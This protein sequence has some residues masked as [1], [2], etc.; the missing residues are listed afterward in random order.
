MHF[1][2]FEIATTSSTPRACV[3]AT[4]ARE[5]PRAVLHWTQSQGLISR[6]RSSQGVVPNSD[7]TTSM[8]PRWTAEDEARELRRE[9][10]E[11]LQYGHR[12][13]SSVGASTA[14][15]RCS[16][17]E[18]ART[19]SAQERELAAAARADADTAQQEC[20]TVEAELN[21]V[22]RELLRLMASQKAGE[23]ESWQTALDPWTRPDISHDSIHRVRHWQVRCPFRQL[24]I[25]QKCGNACHGMR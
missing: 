7:G 10:E 21:E 23:P 22:Q 20:A 12:Q 19:A 24:S 15:V 1:V 17:A 18:M 6:A 25:V 5:P 14:L 4:D 3:R 2:D 16:S 13:L 8:M 11:R 9:D